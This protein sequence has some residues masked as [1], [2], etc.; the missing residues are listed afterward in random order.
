[1]PK[2]KHPPPTPKDPLEPLSLSLIADINDSLPA[3]TSFNPWVDQIANPWLPPD[4]SIAWQSSNNNIGFAAQP[5]PSAVGCIQGL[6]QTVYDTIHRMSMVFPRMKDARRN[7][8]SSFRILLT[9]N[10]GIPR[11]TLAMRNIIR[12]ASLTE[13]DYAYPHLLCFLSSY[14]TRKCSSHY[15]NSIHFLR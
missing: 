8:K 2:A 5:F 6:Q 11:Y 1:M 12:T 15:Y 3:P 14:S 7:L 13:E 10:H 4:I 9:A